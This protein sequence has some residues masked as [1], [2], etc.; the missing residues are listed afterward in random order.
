MCKRFFELFL[1][2]VNRTCS[3][4]RQLNAL[5]ITDASGDPSSYSPEGFTSLCG[6]TKLELRGNIIHIEGSPFAKTRSLSVQATGSRPNAQIL[7]STVTSAPRLKSLTIFSNIH[8]IYVGNIPTVTSQL[9]T[10][11]LHLSDADYTS[12]GILLAPLILPSLSKLTLIHAGRHPPSAIP[13]LFTYVAAFCSKHRIT[14]LTLLQVPILAPDLVLLFEEMIIPLTALYILESPAVRTITPVL[15]RGI[16]DTLPVLTRLGLIWSENSEID[17]STV[18]GLIEMRT[19]AAGGLKSATVGRGEAHHN[20]GRRT[21]ERLSL[22]CEEGLKCQIF[23]E[24]TYSRDPICEY[25]KST[26]ANGWSKF[27]E[28]FKY[29]GNRNKY[30]L[31][32]KSHENLYPPQILCGASDKEHNQGEDTEIGKATEV[33]G[34]SQK[35]HNNTVHGEIAE[36]KGW[37]SWRQVRETSQ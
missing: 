34:T 37:A 19:W 8:N 7:A 5:T 25:Y 21:R 15:L 32:R 18:M 27:L 35:P 30:L 22:L 12:F 4:L 14:D 17:E 2:T 13:L 33:K 29:I 28:R 1:Q 11:T 6:V 20:L 10:L 3:D 24:H 16:K 31:M 9:T 26:E 23:T 36:Y